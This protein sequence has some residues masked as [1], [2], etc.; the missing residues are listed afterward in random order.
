MRKNQTS[1]HGMSSGGQLVNP[2]KLGMGGGEGLVAMLRNFI[3]NSQ[4]EE[5]KKMTRFG[6]AGQ[7][8][9][10]NPQLAPKAEHRVIS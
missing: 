4:E 5:K 10:H 3:R 1:V 7:E 6:I 2:F 9:L 8:L